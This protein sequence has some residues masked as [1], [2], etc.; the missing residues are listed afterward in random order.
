[1]FRYHLMAVSKNNV[2]SAY[3]MSIPSLVICL[4]PEVNLKFTSAKSEA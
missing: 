1:M 2:S 3:G 4:L